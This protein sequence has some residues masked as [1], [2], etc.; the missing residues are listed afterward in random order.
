MHNNAQGTV[1]DIEMD[2]YPKPPG[3]MN[4]SSRSS[5][6]F[7]PLT[8]INRPLHTA[9]RSAPT[10]RNKLS[11][12]HDLPI[13]TSIYSR[14]CTACT[15]SQRVFP[16]SI[17]LPCTIEKMMSREYSIRHNTAISYR[18]YFE[19]IQSFAICGATTI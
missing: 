4:S 8:P 10:I 12:E 11:K 14:R 9:K 15:D 6:V 5:P 16:S 3:S 2:S 19:A 17:H 13:Y 1:N 18:Q 7:K